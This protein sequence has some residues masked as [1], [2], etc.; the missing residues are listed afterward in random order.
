MRDQEL[1]AVSIMERQPH[2]LQAI[3]AQEGI[4]VGELV[5]RILAHWWCIA[6]LGV[7]GVLLSLVYLKFRPPV[8]EA[9]AVL[10]IDPARAETLAIADHT[11][12]TP[13]D[14]EEI[15]HT[16]I[17]LLKSDNVAIRALNYLSEGYLRRFTHSPNHPTPI[18]QDVQTLTSEQQGWITRLE[19]AL[20]VKQIDG[21]Q[22]ISVSAR[23][24]D[25]DLSAAIANAVVR[26]Y[27]V[28][29]FEDRSHS[30][31]QLGTWLSTQM[32]QLKHQ[33][34]VSQQKLANFEQ[35][36]GVVEVTDKDNTIGDRLHLLN[37]RL[38][39][40]QSDRMVKEAQLQALKGGSPSEL[41]TLFPNPKLNSL[42]STQGTLTAQY[43]QLSSKFGPNYPPLSDLS[44][45]IHRLDDEIRSEAQSLT[46]RVNA[47]YQGAKRA[48]AMLQGE[49][50]KQIANA[51]RFDRNQA[52]YDVLRGDVTASKEMYDALR[53]KLQQ[54]TVDAELDGL[55][56]MLVQGAR[57]PMEPAGPGKLFILPVSLIVGIFAGVVTV[58]SFS[59][60]SDRVR[61]VQQIER[62]LGVPVLAR[63]SGKTQEIYER[64]GC[65][66]TRSVPLVL[67]KSSSRAAA[68]IRALRNSLVLAEGTKTVLVTSDH[69]ALG[70][71]R[72]A[73]NLGVALAH[74][75]AKVLLV[76]A[77]LEEPRIQDEFDVDNGSGLGEFL[78]KESE[79]LTPV[80]PLPRLDNLLL[81]TGGR[82]AS[83][84]DLLSS[85]ALRTLLLTWKKEF[86]FVVLAGTPLLASNAGMPLASWVDSTILV[87]QEG[88]SRLRELKKIRDM[89]LR[90]NARIHGLV[91]NT[92]PR[93]LI[94]TAA[95]RKEVRYVFPD[96]VKQVH[97][98]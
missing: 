75:G 28:Q 40:A 47:D 2:S 78:A 9:T 17:V 69:E 11:A 32:D 1:Q 45:Q 10:R 55:N 39:A 13:L 14:P 20:T 36:N 18:P 77:A 95:Q 79:S 88:Q 53:R 43:A 81:V 59:G 84:A 41:A 26:A 27:T 54:A 30:V 60:T 46:E 80:R 65:I 8:Y 87:V 92:A 16:E 74:S 37:E 29:T 44:K 6:V 7:V 64:S 4:T 19:R 56:M 51:F 85:N 25:P 66:A 35:A 48:E 98:D 31:G 91:I 82:S 38:A 61:D 49:Y 97:V 34:E 62:E 86:D 24:T 90:H 15:L 93:R 96:L 76:D 33:V 22:L 12:A 68:E 50:D 70:A 67:S 71:L 23:T 72:I 57:V 58:L 89:L 5:R 94:G 21:T 52:Q 3:R 83:C 73:V 42:E 63:L